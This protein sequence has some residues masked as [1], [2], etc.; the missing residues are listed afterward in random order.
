[1]TENASIT[2]ETLFDRTQRPT[3]APTRRSRFRTIATFALLVLLVALI[4]GYLF[5]TDPQRVRDISQSY[6]SQL[7]GGPVTVERASLSIFEGLRLDGIRISVDNRGAPDSLLLEAKSL[8]IGYNPAAL[9]LGRIEATRILALEPR[10]HVVEDADAGIWNF[11]RLDP[12]GRKNLA[13]DLSN[14]TSDIPLPE[15]LLRNARFDYAQIAKGTRT[16]VG[17]LTIEGQLTPDTTGGTYRFR[18][19]SRGGTSGVFPIAEGWLEP[20]GKQLGVVLR[21]VEFV[22]EIKTILPAVVRRFWEEHQLA[23][24]I[25]ETRVSYFRHESGKAGFRVETDLDGVRLV[26]PPDKWMGPRERHRIDRWRSS[27]TRIASPTLGG[28]P[29][30]KLLIDAM[31][32]GPL[33][34]DEVD[35]TFVFTDQSIDISDLVARIENNRFKLSGQLL[36]YG[37]SA[38]FKVRVES[39]RSENIRIPEAPRYIKSMPW[40][41]QEIY[42]RFRPVGEA[43]FW[44]EARRDSPG[45]KPAIAGQVN[46]HNAAFTFE[47]F[48]YPID[49][50]SG[51]LKIDTDP[52]TGFERLQVIALKGHGYRGGANEDATVE[53]MGTVSPLDENAGADIVVRGQN[54]VSEPLLIES[55]PPQTKKTVK[56][57]DADNT[58]TLPTFKG[59]FECKIHCPQ[60][61]SRHWDIVT[62]LDVQNASGKLAA[63]P[64]PLKN[65][66]MDMVVHDSFIQINQAR[67]ERDGAAISLSGRVDWQKRIPGTN[68]PLVQTDLSLKA[69]R[70]PIDDALLDAL[71]EAKRKWLREVK[72]AG[73]VDVEGKIVPETP[74]SDDPVADI[75]VVLRGGTMQ[76]MGD[77]VALSDINAEGRIAASKASIGKATAKR[78]DAVVEGKA[79]FDWTDESH[80]HVVAGASVR[81]LEIDKALVASLP[82]GARRSVEALAPSGTVDLDIDFAAGG[83][84]V[85][86]RPR[87]LSIKPQSLGLELKELGGEVTFNRQSV[88]L[89]EVTARLGD[90][91]LQA[92]GTVVPESG[93]T[94]LSLAGRDLKVT[95]ALLAALPE[96]VRRVMESAELR[97][98]VA[99][100][101]SRLSITPKDQ[102]NDVE[103]A[104]AV[105]L[106][107]ASLHAGV[108]MTE[109]NGVV[110]AKG[111]ASGGQIR[112]LVGDITFDS[113]KLAGRDVQ[114]LTATM[115]KP[116]DQDLL[117]IGKIDGRIAGG[118]IGGQID[119][120]LSAKDPRFGLSLVL[121]NAN[122]T[123]LTGE[124]EK[125]IDGRLTASLSLEGRWDDVTTRRGRGDVLVEGKQMYRV[126]VLFGLMQ[127]ANLTLPLDAP[128]QQAGVRYAV[129]G[130]R[131]TLDAIDLR[132]KTTVMQGSGWI[133]FGTKQVQM[134]LM[135]GNS[136]A[137]A[138]P[139]FGELIRG[140]RQDLLQIRVKG[141]LEEPKVGASAFNTIT[142]TVDEVLKGDK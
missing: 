39:L 110:T 63:F 18:L 131:V 68:E 81:G 4:G 107:D 128:L 140:A 117:Q 94:T 86:A 56:R 136:A 114:K 75:A 90:A 22:D 141:S 119:S 139:I 137:D 93:A 113:L 130:N 129:D 20:G 109:A 142:T 51:T 21:D 23:G 95:D 67:M 40:P 111:H 16:D 127:I 125:P 15:I 14:D 2:I 70:V 83:Y 103:F 10:V 91:K 43:S 47:R 27:F 79:S 78:G 64:Y 123:E 52:Q 77:A 12:P 126:P 61:T 17:T 102:S 7:T 101:L 72:L 104:G 134:T 28:S 26:V 1:M 37:P 73:H 122:V 13:R 106:S 50:A 89:K 85:V 29:V 58:G 45:A 96:S 108:P 80:P 53:V 84:R 3:S 116:A 92:S 133:D 120:I 33:Q 48:P 87:S 35:G 8:H 132:G 6:L 74:D 19:Q 118:Q 60:G 65:L 32:P 42:Y 66:A 99:F 88:T 25:D 82:D 105:W 57:F 24:R 124:L 49:R 71:P 115:I 55:M 36:G 98:T 38:A 11:Q 34:L 41:V 62:S 46:V 69:T 54:L 135:M 30:A 97:G 59:S 112:E 9:L 100:E 31:Q 5:I 121:R 76:L 138:V 44:L